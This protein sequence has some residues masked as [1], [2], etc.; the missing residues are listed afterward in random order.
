MN[1]QN[2]K[3]LRMPSEAKAAERRREKQWQRIAKRAQLAARKH[4]QY[5]QQKNESNS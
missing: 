2:L 1:W 4:A 3:S 5:Q